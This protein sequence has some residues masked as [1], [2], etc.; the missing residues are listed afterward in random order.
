MH[1]GSVERSVPLI[2]ICNFSNPGSFFHSSW[3]ERIYFQHPF[4]PRSL[5]EPHNLVTELPM[6]FPPSTPTMWWTSPTSSLSRARFAARRA[7]ALDRPSEPARS[8]S[9]RFPLT[10]SPRL[11]RQEKSTHFRPSAD[12]LF[13]VAM[14]P[15]R[16]SPH[17][18]VPR[19]AFSHEVP[20]VP[21]WARP[22][23][24]AMVRRCES[25]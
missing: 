9:P 3:R 8:P 25:L 17:S 11:G 20:R 22:T 21:R 10:S 7:T 13:K 19:S 16:S 14:A 12:Y 23:A 6:Q 15:R 4:Y 1:Q 2:N 24:S 5:S 18:E